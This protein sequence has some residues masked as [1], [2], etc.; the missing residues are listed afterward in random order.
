MKEFS[1]FML[2]VAVAVLGLAAIELYAQ[3]E[4][5]RDDLRTERAS[6]STGPC[7]TE[8]VI[9]GLGKD[10]KSAA[11]AGKIMTLDGTLRFFQRVKDGQQEIIEQRDGKEVV[12]FHRPLPLQRR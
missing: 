4:Q 11:V 12:V 3:R 2:L 1:G 5:L 9:S 6:Y 8:F 10:G 7:G